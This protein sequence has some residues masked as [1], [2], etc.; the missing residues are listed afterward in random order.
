[1]NCIKGVII[2][3]SLLPALLNMACAGEVETFFPAKKW[4]KRAEVATQ[5]GFVL[6]TTKFELFTSRASAFPGKAEQDWVVLTTEN[7]TPILNPD[8]T[9]GTA[10]TFKY[11]QVKAANANNFVQKLSLVDWRQ[12]TV[13][14]RLF[15]CDVAGTALTFFGAK[16]TVVDV[17]GGAGG[18]PHVGKE[19]LDARQAYYQL[20]AALQ[21][22]G[23]DKP[24]GKYP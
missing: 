12:P 21:N 17:C 11:A 3:L 19:M 8:G 13:Y 23:M 10:K 18:L 15:L 6:S 4:A 24:A 1:M 20:S 5:G 14:D 16:Q 7:L 2:S 9:A 22:A